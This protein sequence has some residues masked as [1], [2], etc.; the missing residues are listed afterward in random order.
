MLTIG[1]ALMCIGV[2][3]VVGGGVVGL[4]MAFIAQNEFDKELMKKGEL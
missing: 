1:M 4:I 3:A 2:G